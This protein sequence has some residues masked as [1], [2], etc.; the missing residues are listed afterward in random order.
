MSAEI[1]PG[2]DEW[3]VVEMLGHRRMV[4]RVREATFPAGFLR[5]DEPD[6]RTA[7]IA[8]ASLYAIHPVTE[9]EARAVADKWRTEPIA[10]WELPEEWRHR[11]SQAHAG[12]CGRRPHRRRG[13]G[14][15]RPRL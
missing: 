10:R 6:G 7:I 1:P 12:R 4:G 9:E 5:V 8:P 3:C 13:H 14:H 15:G 2:F 11:R